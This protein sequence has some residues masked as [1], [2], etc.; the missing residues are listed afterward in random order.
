MDK[1]NYDKVRE[2]LNSDINSA[3]DDEVRDRFS[4]TDTEVRHALRD[5]WDELPEGDLPIESTMAFD[6]F[7]RIV[8]DALIPRQKRS[9]VFVRW[10]RNVAAVMLLPVAVLCTVLLQRP[11]DHD[12]EWCE[13]IVE[14]GRTDS[15]LLPD[16]SLV[17]LN[18]GSH[19]IYPRSFD[20]SAT[21]KVFLSG[22]GYFDVAHDADHPFIVG[23]GDINVRVHGTQFNITSYEN[24]ESI[25]VCLMDGSISLDVEKNGI[26][27]NVMLVPGDVARYDRSTGDIEQRRMQTDAYLSWRNGGFYFNNQPLSEI[28]AQFE[29]VFGV[30]IHI[31]DKS[32][33]SMVYTLAFV[34]N[35]SLDMMLNAIAGYELDIE[36]SAEIIIIR[37]KQH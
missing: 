30:E 22:E 12:V 37:K 4:E 25:S 34:N 15:L 29:R 10:F 11:A 31:A 20:G 1:T 35:E 3:V 17:W 16:N 18:A 8:G 6:R 36:K 13:F 5:F 24:M 14:A 27:R 2:Y 28:V 19:L 7:R 21:R 33:A 32:V 9:E 26:R 23:A